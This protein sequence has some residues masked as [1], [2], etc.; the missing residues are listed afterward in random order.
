VIDTTGTFDVLRLHEA[1][2]SRVRI[3]IVTAKAQYLGDPEDP[4]YHPPPPI[5]DAEKKADQV[6]DRVRIL[7]VFDFV[8]VVEAVN[9]LT[10]ELEA[11]STEAVLQLP[12]EV[13]QSKNL[14][15]PEQ[16]REIADSDEDEE[17]ML[18]DA[19]SPVR[20][21]THSEKQ[22]DDLL[23]QSREKIGMI[24]VDNISQVVNPILKTNYVR[25]DKFARAHPLATR[26]LTKSG[27]SLL[28]TFLCSLMHLTLTHD[29]ATLLLNSANAPK[30]TYAHATTFTNAPPPS[31]WIQDPTSALPSFV[32]QPSIFASTTA[33]PALGK[34]F[35]YRIDLHILLSQLPK[36]R[37]D[38]EIE[39][40]GKVGLG[41]AEFVNVIEV[42]ADRWDGRMGSWAPFAMDK[43]V[44]LT[45]AF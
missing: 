40:G 38:A 42:L 32:D 36:R 27:Q 1:I 16:R 15:D 22:A 30:S 18:F 12:S 34:A 13:L 5:E 6:L 37:R 17:D 31:T 21:R 9:E 8:G 4:N 45:A 44:G 43:D 2:V 33:R 39:F 14:P 23:S 19:P 3:K 28:T 35:T 41:R 26:V 11:Y 7:R 25:G 20:D 24:I 10:E 29:I